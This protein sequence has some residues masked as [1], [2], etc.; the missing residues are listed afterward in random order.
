MFV[1][2]LSFNVMWLQFMRN[3]VYACLYFRVMDSQP[4]SIVKLQRKNRGVK[5]I[6]DDET[7]ENKRK[8]AKLIW[9]FIA[10]GET[11][12]FSLPS[13]DSRWPTDITLTDKLTMDSSRV[14]T[15]KTTGDGE[16]SAQFIGKVKRKYQ[17][18]ASQKITRKRIQNPEGSVA[19]ISRI[20]LVFE[21]P[22]VIT[23]S[24]PLITLVV[25]PF[26]ILA[27][28]S[29]AYNFFPA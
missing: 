10:Q 24:L 8:A 11:T 21:L 16:F 3:F 28:V 17:D 5:I 23:S 1:F 7:E 25:R 13:N 12:P 4:F 18:E 29:K 6:R 27:S 9:F 22:S 14:V 19:D 20:R 15:F 2:P 26:S